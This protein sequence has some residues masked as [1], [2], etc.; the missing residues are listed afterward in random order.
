VAKTGAHVGAASQSEDTE[1]RDDAQKALKQMGWKPAIAH[2]TVQAAAEALR[3][4]MTLERLVAE[5]LRR[6]PQSHYT[7]RPAPTA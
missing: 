4:N 1:L 6:C 3:G 5:A 2:A 7:T